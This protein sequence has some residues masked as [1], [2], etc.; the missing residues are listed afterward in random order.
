MNEY[1][2]L[3]LMALVSVLL[4]SSGCSTLFPT[5]T[6]TPTNA[7]TATPTAKPTQTPTATHTPTVTPTATSTSTP[8]HTPTITRTPIP[9]T[10]TLAPDR[11]Y[12]EGRVY[13]RETNKPIV[14][15][16]VEVVKNNTDN[17]FETATDAKGFFSISDL[18]PGEYRM[19]VKWEIISYSVLPCEQLGIKVPK[20]TGTWFVLT[21]T[22]NNGNKA[23]IAGS[24]SEFDITSGSITRIDIELY[25]A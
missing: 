17:S 24:V 15:G 7:P 19:T 1:V 16:A 20:G 9:P 11:A 14:G 25:C 4:F 13:F 23:V 22:L 3:K 5:P 10:S 6:T 8:A 12:V 2:I 21:G 18:G